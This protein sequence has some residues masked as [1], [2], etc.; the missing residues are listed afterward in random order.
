MA[1]V[2]AVRAVVA[3]NAVS[4]GTQTQEFSTEFSACTGHETYTDNE[5]FTHV[6]D[7]QSATT[8]IATPPSTPP[9]FA[10]LSF[11]ASQALNLSSIPSL[12]SSLPSSLL[13]LSSRTPSSVDSLL[14]RCPICEDPMAGRTTLSCS[15]IAGHSFCYKCISSHKQHNGRNC[16]LC[17]ATITAE[18]HDHDVQNAIVDCVRNDESISDD[19]RA[20][21]DTNML[22]WK[23]AVEE[24]RG[25][26][27]DWMADNKTNIDKGFV[28]M[29][30][31]T[32][33]GFALPAAITFVMG[34]RRAQQQAAAS[35]RT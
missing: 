3:A 21:F 7:D 10:S 26:W 27:R 18:T 8:I 31:L 17:R 19:E 22:V 16:P 25:G 34:T 14:M 13:P 23:L 30:G 2:Q 33:A 12:P 24:R 32:V 6:Q 1:A 15:P 29:A 28:L 20:E 4:V 35:S 11:T 5:G 9:E